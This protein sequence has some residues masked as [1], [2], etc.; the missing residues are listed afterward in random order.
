MSQGIRME[1]I[2]SK[3]VLSKQVKVTI[4]NKH[5]KKIDEFFMRGGMNLWVFIRKHGLPIGSACSGVGVCAACDVKITPSQQKFVSTQND[6]EKETLK[7]NTKPQDARLA[8]LC[9]VYQDI[10]VQADYW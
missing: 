2:P 10:E 4:L 7:R 6:F 3:D 5:G 9:R 8:C 1:K